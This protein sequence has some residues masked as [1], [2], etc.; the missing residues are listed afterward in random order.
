M[1]TRKSILIA[2]DEPQL[3]V[4][5]RALLDQPASDRETYEI[6][7]ATNGA[8]ALALAK[9]HKP[10][11]IILDWMMPKMTGIEVASSLRDCEATSHIPIIML[12]AR[13]QDR[14][15]QAGLIAGTAHYITKPFSPKHLREVVERA[16]EI[17]SEPQPV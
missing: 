1:S 9:L 15:R 2:D 10:D 14:D 4:L 11:M 7:E 3:R 16:L 17:R 13:G 12:T 6:I 5:L 8:E